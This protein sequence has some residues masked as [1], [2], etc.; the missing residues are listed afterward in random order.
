MKKKTKDTISI[1][2]FALILIMMMIIAT[3]P[4]HP[5][6]P[7][8]GEK[9]ILWSL[10]FIFALIR[11]IPSKEAMIDRRIRKMARINKREQLIK[12]WMDSKETREKLQK[13]PPTFPV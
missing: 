2:I 5:F 6:H 12:E 1:I 11:I 9:I 4:S 3:N 7:S 8:L 13:I 10:L